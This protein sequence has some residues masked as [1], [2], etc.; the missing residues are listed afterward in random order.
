MGVRMAIEVAEIKWDT[1]GEAVDGLPSTMRFEVDLDDD[2]PSEMEIND[3]AAD[4]MSDETG[5]CVKGFSFVSAEKVGSS[6]PKP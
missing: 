3:A 6:L 2:E 1:D 4:H 5:F